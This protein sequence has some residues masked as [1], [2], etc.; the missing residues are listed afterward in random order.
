M[1]Q[2]SRIN[3]GNHLSQDMEDWHIEHDGLNATGYDNQSQGSVQT[4]GQRRQYN[5]SCLGVLFGS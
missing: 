3:G 1:I 4:E 5:P 2:L